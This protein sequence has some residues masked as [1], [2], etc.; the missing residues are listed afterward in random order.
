MA[1]GHGEV[2]EVVP[3]PEVDPAG[4][5]GRLQGE[6]HVEL[7]RRPEERRSGQ[8]RSVSALPRFRNVRFPYF[9]AVEDNH[10]EAGDVV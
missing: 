3:V 2:E 1:V 4:V 7:V 8:V 5:G 9:P 10:V 6:K